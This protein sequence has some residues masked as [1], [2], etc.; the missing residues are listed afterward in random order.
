MAFF[1]RER[2][3]E[4]L[5]RHNDNGTMAAYHKK[6]KEVVNDATNPPTILAATVQQPIDVSGPALEAVLGAA[7]Q[8]ALLQAQAQTLVIQQLS[9]QL[10]AAT[11]ERDTARDSVASLEALVVVRNA[12]IAE[13]EAQVAALTPAS[14]AQAPAEDEPLV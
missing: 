1:E 5:I 10:T 4:T 14:N 7:T 12:R 8:Q 13:L 9:G 2:E 11:T 3:Y 6:I